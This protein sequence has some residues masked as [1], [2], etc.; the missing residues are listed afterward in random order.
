VHA[1]VDFLAAP[2]VGLETDA[3][4]EQLNFRGKFGRGGRRRFFLVR[5]G[6]LFRWLWRSFLSNADVSPKRRPEAQ[7]SDGA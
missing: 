2:A 3:G 5:I 6:E 4:F 1:G 7:R